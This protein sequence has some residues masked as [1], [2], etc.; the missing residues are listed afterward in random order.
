MSEG[1]SIQSSAFMSIA[2]LMRSH[3]TRIEGYRPGEQPP[4]HDRVIKLNTN[5]N[6]Y[7]PSP[8][9]LDALQSIG[10]ELLRRYPEPTANAFR[11]TA[12]TLLNLPPE[13][14]SVGNGSD[15]LLSLIVRAF[16]GPGDTVAYPWPTYV[17]YKTLT[18]LEQGVIKAIPF[19]NTFELPLEALIQTEAKVTFIASPASPSG[20][21]IPHQHLCQ[22]AE[23]LTGLLIIDEAYVDFAEESA[24][25]LVQRFDR[26]IILRTL[27]KGYS[28]AGLRLGFAIASPETIQALNKVKDSYSVDAIACKLGIAA[29]NDQAHKNQN[30][31]RVK[32]SRLNLS[33]QLQSLGCKVW[34]SVTNFLWVHPP[35]DAQQLTAAL[36]TQQIYIRHFDL[37][38]LSDKVRITIGTDEQQAQL[39]HTLKAIL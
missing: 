11:E 32:R 39:I 33:Q 20:T 35:M 29:L 27:S 38:G 24:L 31:E 23:S 9:V 36:K 14:F 8:L 21:A 28:L 3:L 4:P 37:P 5:E 2:N 12:G 26:V 13:Y 16:I 1:Y 19:G 34:P 18:E 30:A 6:P 22:L 10:G 17:L 15:H 7:P 25:D